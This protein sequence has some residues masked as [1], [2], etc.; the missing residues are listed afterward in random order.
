MSVQTYAIVQRALTAGAT[1][2]DAT[3]RP[4]IQNIGEFLSYLNDV[5]LAQGYT[6]HT[7][8]QVPLVGDVPLGTVQYAY[9]LVKD[10][11]VGKEK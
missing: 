6:I 7:I 10:V 1:I 9:H 3:G 4:A 8:N 5:Y 11:A 2:N